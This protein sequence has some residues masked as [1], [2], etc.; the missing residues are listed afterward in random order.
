MF[1]EDYLMRYNAMNCGKKLEPM[2]CSNRKVCFIR[3]A[4]G[5]TFQSL[6]LEHG[7]TDVRNLIFI[8]FPVEG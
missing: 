7:N 2:N 8:Q 4:F 1:E 5:N 6:A 3:R